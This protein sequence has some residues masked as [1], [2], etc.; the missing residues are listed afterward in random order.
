VGETVDPRN[1]EEKVER[2]KKQKMQRTRFSIKA[3]I[4]FYC[5]RDTEKDLVRGFPTCAKGKRKS[6]LKKIRDEEKGGGGR[7]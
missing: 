5:Q 3:S 7:G 6:R 1:S 4:I 2:R